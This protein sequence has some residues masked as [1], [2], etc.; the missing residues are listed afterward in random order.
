MRLTKAFW[1]PGMLRMVDWA[2]GNL[3]ILLIARDVFV[4]AGKLPDRWEAFADRVG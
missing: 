2:S 4:L 3:T 1:F